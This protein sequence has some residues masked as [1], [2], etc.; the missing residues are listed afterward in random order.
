MLKNLRLISCVFDSYSR[1]KIVAVE[2][3]FAVYNLKK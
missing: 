3:S 1:Y 2:V